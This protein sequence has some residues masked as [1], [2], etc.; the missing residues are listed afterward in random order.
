MYMIYNV[1]TIYV[2]LWGQMLYAM[3]P[4]TIYIEVIYHITIY[5]VYCIC[6]VRMLNAA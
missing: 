2:M 1:Q 5:I 3:Q 4:I 6:L